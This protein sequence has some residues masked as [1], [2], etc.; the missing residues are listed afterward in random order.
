MPDWHKFIVIMCFSKTSMFTIVAV[1]SVVGSACG[2]TLVQTRGTVIAFNAELG[3][4][5]DAPSDGNKFDVMAPA[6]ESFGDYLS[7]ESTPGTV[8]FDIDFLDDQEYTVYVRYRELVNTPPLYQPHLWRVNDRCRC[9]RRSFH[10]VCLDTRQR[11]E[12]HRIRHNAR[13]RTDSHD[14]RS[15][16]Y[17]FRYRCDS[18]R[19]HLCVERRRIHRLRRHDP[20][21]VTHR[22]RAFQCSAISIVTATSPTSAPIERSRSIPTR[23]NLFY[24]QSYH[25]RLVCGR[26]SLPERSIG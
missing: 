10:Y 17:R 8:S 1:L 16:R 23:P 12:F 9:L 7:V 15:K 26:S 21:G 19:E 22:A 14:Q 24:G 2:V 3:T 6:G 18:P 25:L 4:L 20:R 5:D 13:P 11:I